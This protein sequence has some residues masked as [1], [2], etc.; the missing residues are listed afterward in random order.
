MPHDE[1]PWVDKLTLSK[2]LTATRRALTL[3]TRLVFPLCGLRMSYASW[4]RSR[5]GRAWTVGLGNRAGEH[6]AVWA[7][8]VPQWVILQFA[9]ARIGAVL[10][11]INPAYRPY[12]TGIRAGQCDA[13]A[14]FLVDRFKSS[15]YFAM[16]AEVCPE[17]AHGQP[18]RLHVPTRFRSCAGSSAGGDRPGRRH[19][20]ADVLIERGRRVPPSRLDDH[21]PHA[22]RRTSR[23]TS[24]TLPARPAFPRPPRSAIATC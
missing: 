22:R 8:N 17:L 4:R 20:L 5:S 2:V 19:H 11:T 10:V 15:D 16:L 12:R 18:G 1:R 6:V 21:R 13:V 9:T 14:L 7:T 24:N 3:S 23:S